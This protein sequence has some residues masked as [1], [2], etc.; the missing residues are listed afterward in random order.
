MKKLKSTLLVLLMATISLVAYYFYI[1]ISGDVKSNKSEDDSEQRGSIIAEQPTS[2]QPTSDSN[3][4]PDEAI[5]LSL[6][7]VGD[8]FAHESVINSGKQADGAYNYDFLFADTKK[9]IESADIAVIFQTMIIAGNDKGVSGYPVFNTPEEMISAIDNAG[10]DVALM[11]SNHSNDKGTNGIEQC[12]NLWKEKSDVMAVGINASEQES[13]N[14]PIIE[15]KGKKIAVLN[16]TT[17]MNNPIASASKRYMVN[18]L[19]ALNPTTGNVS[20]SK[21]S[22]SVINDIQR[23]DEQ[24]DFVVVFPYWGTEYQYSASDIQKSW[25]KQMTEAGADLIIGARSHYLGDIEEITAD[26]G[27]TSMCYY[28]LGN[29]CSSFNDGDAMVGGMARVNIVFEKDKA[30]VDTAASGIMPIITHYSHSKDAGDN[31]AKLIGV[32]P[33]SEYS[34]EMASSHGIITRANVGFSMEYIEKIIRDK[35]KEDYLMRE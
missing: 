11:A 22:E 24:A 25:A 23:A 20:S 9:Y 27:N 5:K 8:N 18:Y 21:L 32:Y 35:V 7:A 33:I 14:I 17:D 12:I 26:N 19:G 29:F 31:N 16:Y 30:Y 3:S 13:I 4:E 34:S 1:A 28:S 6:V 2:E 15:A 10:F